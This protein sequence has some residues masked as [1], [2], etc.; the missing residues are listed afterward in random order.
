MARV[1]IEDCMNNNPEILNR[2][3]LVILASERS[4]DIM[5]GAERTLDAEPKDKNTVYA[6]REIAKKKL[7]IDRLRKNIKNRML[8]SENDAGDTSYDSESVDD[9][10][11]EEFDQNEIDVS[12]DDEES[13][14]E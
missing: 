11:T 8:M 3:E 7:N 9:S 5:S 13:T 1:T 12:Y 10:Y 4:R 2:F 6:L 14:T